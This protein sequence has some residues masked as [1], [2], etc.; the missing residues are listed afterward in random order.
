VRPSLSNRH[1]YAGPGSGSGRKGKRV[2]WTHGHRAS[3]GS[4]SPSPRSCLSDGETENDDDDE[5]IFFDAPNDTSFVFS[6]TEGTP[7]PRKHSVGGATGLKKK[8]KPRD[9][10]VSLSDDGGVSMNMGAGFSMRK[11]GTLG[12]SGSIGGM[13]DFLSVMLRASNS[14][15]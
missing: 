11:G 3:T 1:S 13:A 8:Y 6:V 9:S 12:A 5:D 4:E 7:S 2:P 15:V 10:G 14:D